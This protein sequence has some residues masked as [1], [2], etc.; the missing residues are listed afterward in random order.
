MMLIAIKS[1]YN[2]IVDYEKD[3]KYIRSRQFTSYPNENEKIL[4]KCT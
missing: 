3:I 4:D 1:I 2:F